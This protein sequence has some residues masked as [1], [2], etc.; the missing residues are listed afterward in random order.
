MSA[1][2]DI[3][4]ELDDHGFQDTSTTRKLAI[5]NDVAHDINSREAWSYLEA[6]AQVPLTAGDNTPTAPANFNKALSFTIPS[7]GIVLQPERL[8]VLA[9]TYT[10]LSARGTP[11]YYYFV[12]N[13]LRV[14]WTPDAS[15][16]AEM[17]Y[18][19][20]QPTLTAV[21]IETDILLPARHHRVLVLGSLARLYA[22]ED[23]PELAAL[24]DGQ[25]ERRI[26]QMTE[27]LIVRQYDRPER[28]YDVWADDDMWG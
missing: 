13:E 27:D 24:F 8:D 19:R 16:T 7:Q 2:T 10:D 5:I 11:T 15:Y 14:F 9:K 26:T 6:N 18:V 17:N 20:I 23:D 28:V 25:Y 21:S 1:V 12:G 4:A 22:M 3:I